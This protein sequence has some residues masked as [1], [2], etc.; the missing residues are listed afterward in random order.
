M[1]KYLCVVLI[2]LLLLCCGCKGKS[3]KN[4]ETFF[5]MD[6]VVSISAD[7]DSSVIKEALDLCAYYEN[8]F[9]RTK[10]QS[11]V[12]KINAVDGYVKVNEE[13][14]KLIKAAKHYGELSEGRFDVTVCPVSSLYD[15]K[16]KLLPKD[17]DIAKALKKVD[18][19]KIEIS[20]CN[21]ALRDAQLDL[22]GIAKG[23]ITDK[24][25]ELLKSKGVK[26]ATVNIG[27]NVYCFGD[28]E[29][30]IGIRKPF[31]DEIAATIIWGDGTFVTSGIYQRYI[32]KDGKIYH[33]II[34]TKTGYGVENDLSSV[35]VIGE[36]SMDADA[37]STVCMLM[38]SNKGTQLIDTISG[39]EAVFI[40]RDGS[41]KV[42]GGLNINNNIIT[43]K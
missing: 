24:T 29:N 5:M 10:E 25:V 36:N 32:E 42:T 43:A 6:T 34:D 37:L 11:D 38:G 20:D 40:L 4:T 17:D 13:T 30:R 27:G 22:G 3:Y 35:T 14:V 7:C 15:Y 23:Y 1:K 18:Y 9:S 19:K 8:M 12:Y 2:F 41:I 28:K 26:R 31:S 33:H 39:I 16:N 21:V